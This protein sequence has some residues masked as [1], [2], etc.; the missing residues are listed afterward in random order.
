MNVEESPFTLLRSQLADNRA[1][2]RTVECLPLIDIAGLI[3]RKD[4][5]EP[6]SVGGRGYRLN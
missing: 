6:G 2:A 4:V 5:G 1:P 3:A